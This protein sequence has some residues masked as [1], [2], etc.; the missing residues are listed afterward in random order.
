MF[1]SLFSLFGNPPSKS[2]VKAPRSGKTGPSMSRP[3]NDFRAVSID[4]SGPRCAAAK[5]VAEQRFLMREAPRLPLADCT[6]TASCAC[7]FRKVP[8]RR[9]G[10]R[11]LFGGTGSNVWYSGTDSRKSGSRRHSE[12]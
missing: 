9:D 11:R 4:S 5:H 2:P 6:M 1:K 10:D 3:A 7:R 12:T 8:D